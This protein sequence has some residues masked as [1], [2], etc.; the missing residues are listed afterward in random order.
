MQGR[1]PRLKGQRGMDPCYAGRDASI[2]PPQA[3]RH[4]GGGVGGILGAGAAGLLPAVPGRARRR[5]LRADPRRQRGPGLAVDLARAAGA[6]AL[7]RGVAVVLLHRPAGA[8]GH[9][10]LRPLPRARDGVPLALLVPEQLLRAALAD[11][12]P[13]GPAHTQRRC[14][15]PSRTTVSLFSWPSTFR[16][17]WRAGPSS[18]SRPRSNRCRFTSAR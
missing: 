1:A 11:L 3:A 5:R 13:D 7:T 4:G 10:V 14:S 15:R 9:P 18:A 12:A 8:A 17:R 6:A 16:N 2:Q